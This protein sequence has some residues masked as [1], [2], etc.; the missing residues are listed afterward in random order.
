MKFRFKF[1]LL[2]GGIEYRSFHA[3]NLY[4]AKFAALYYALSAAFYHGEVLDFEWVP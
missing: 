4:D 3:S 2:N 1:L